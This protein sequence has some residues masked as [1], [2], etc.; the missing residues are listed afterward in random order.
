MEKYLQKL[1]EF[2]PVSSRQQNVAQLTSYLEDH[3]KKTGLHTTSLSYEGVNS[4]Y[5][6]TS[7]TKQSKLLLQAHI[8]VVPGE[9]QVFQNREDKYFGRGVYDM[10]FATACYM[11][12]CDELGD[13]LNNM[14]LALMFSGDEELGGFNGVKKMLEAG[15]STQ[16]CVLPDAGKGMGTLNVAAKGIYNCTVRIHGQSHHGS[17]PWE[18]DGAAIKLAKFLVELDDLFDTSDQNN[19]TV[20]VAKLIAG[21]AD[22]QGPAF[23]DVILDIRYSD[24]Q[25]LAKIKTKLHSLLKRYQGEV[26][27][28]V[29]GNDYQLNTNNEFVKEFINLYEKEHGSSI[30]FVK[31]HGSS[32][33]R[34]FAERDIPVIMLRPDGGGAHGDNEWISAE[35][36]EKFY[37]LLKKYVLKIATIE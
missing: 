32:D 22:N 19:S 29:E 35:S 17:R 5:C 6:S 10:L 20:T 15:Y 24:K 8:D 26:I 31:A 33:A 7:T 34:F 16:V 23:A 25:D 11:R 1:V 3:F 21:D 36:I 4:L 28:L 14:N 12:L 2:Y 13:T 18:G 27:L 37:R 9:S 30:E